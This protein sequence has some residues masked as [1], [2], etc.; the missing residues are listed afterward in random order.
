ML[1][2]LIKHAVLVLFFHGMFGYFDK[3]QHLE[4]TFFLFAIA[5][6]AFLCYHDNGLRPRQLG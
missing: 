2:D 3:M 6:F 1:F 5:F 4:I